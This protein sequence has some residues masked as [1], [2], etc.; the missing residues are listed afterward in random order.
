MSFHLSIFLFV[1]WGKIIDAKEEMHGRPQ[2]GNRVP[3]ED[4]YFLDESDFTTLSTTETSSMSTTSTL[5]SPDPTPHNPNITSITT[6]STN[7]ASTAKCH[8]QE[9]HVTTL[10]GSQLP[11]NPEGQSQ[12]IITESPQEDSELVSEDPFM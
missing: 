11:E 7:L 9:A 10:S 1:Y 3:V 6:S 4:K 8:V 2:C 5:T 12:M